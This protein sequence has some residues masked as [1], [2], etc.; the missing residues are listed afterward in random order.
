MIRLLRTNILLLA[1]F[2]AFLTAE[3]LQFNNGDR[4]SGKVI[5]QEDGKIVFK[6]DLLGEVTVSADEATVVPSEKVADATP[7]PAV[8]ATAA[9]GPS[10]PEPTEEQIAEDAEAESM[11]NESLEVA[12]SYIEK[13]V[14]PG[15][16]GKYNVGLAMT[17]SDS[18][19][20][21]FNTS[22]EMKKDSGKHHYGWDAYY[23]YNANTDSAGVNDKTTDKYGTGFAYRYDFSERW[24]LQSDTTYLR[25]AV[26][27]IRHQVTENVSIGYKI[28]DEETFK[29]SV[30]P[31]IAAQYN[32][33]VGSDEKWLG[34][35][36]FKENLTY[37]FSE[38][39]N[40]AQ[41]AYVRISPSG[42]DDIQWGGQ[43][44]L[45]A[46]LNKWIVASIVYNYTYDGTV[47]P[48]SSKDEQ[49]TTLQLGFPF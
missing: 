8:A 33:V 2:P 38:T 22:I 29:L 31:G 17:E 36:T 35:G 23:N 7:A 41:D 27:Q 13:V 15:W 6:S 44:A 26:K 47:G 18:K 11:F 10:A 28:Y 39:F 37:V 42:I 1:L 45:N 5:S 4:I 34:F 46:N 19:S 12:R 9:P 32:D 14:P 43:I 20:T 3:V 25:D 16:T 40:L 30:A 48:G 49:T 21:Q 24:F